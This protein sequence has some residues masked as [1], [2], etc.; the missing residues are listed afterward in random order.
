[1]TVRDIADGKCTWFL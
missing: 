1:M